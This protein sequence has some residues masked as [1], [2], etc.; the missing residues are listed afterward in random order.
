MLR[1]VLFCLCTAALAGTA[2]ADYDAGLTAYA[3][4]DFEAAIA[5]WELLAEEGHAE[6]QYRLGVM[7]V[8]GQGVPIRLKNAVEYYR[9]AA[10][11]GHAEAQ[12]A[13]AFMYRVGNGV[14]QSDEE[15]VKW[16]RLAAEQGVGQAQ[17]NLGSMYGGGRGI[18]R[19]YVQAYK[20]FSLAAMHGVDDARV[21]LFYCADKLTEEEIAAAQ[22]LALAWRPQL[23]E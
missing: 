7:H 10:E 5:E 8:S 20:W 22:R 2:L 3:Q 23:S 21:A 17:F 1:R 14:K 19:D 9:M 12:N 11:L 16:Y 6:A 4:G 13:L 15:A 18:E